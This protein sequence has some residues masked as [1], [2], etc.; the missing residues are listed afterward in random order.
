MVRTAVLSQVFAEK[1]TQS[2]PDV[3][4]LGL[5]EAVFGLVEH[6]ILKRKFGGY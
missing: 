5:G 1:K 3:K 2:L 4:S 6:Q